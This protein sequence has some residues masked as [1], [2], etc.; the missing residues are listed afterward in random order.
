MPN[1][2]KI[3]FKTQVAL[4][5][6]PIL[7][8]GIRKYVTDLTEVQSALVDSVIPQRKPGLI[9]ETLMYGL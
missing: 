5:R 8:T 3:P 2:E 4:I 9:S 7:E 6:R 1:E